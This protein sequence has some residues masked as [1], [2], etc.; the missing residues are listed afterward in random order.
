MPTWRLKNL[1]LDEVSL[2]PKGANRRRFTVFKAL[3]DHRKTEGGM[4]FPPAAFAHVPDPT[5]PSTWKLRLWETPDKKVTAAQVGRAVAALG[6]GGFRGNRVQIPAADLPGV[7][8]KVRSAWKQVHPGEKEVPNAIKSL[9]ND[10]MPDLKELIASVA[11][12]DDKAKTELRKALE[13]APDDV[14]KKLTDAT[15]EQKD[16]LRKALGMEPE[17]DDSLKA[18]VMKLFG[19]TPTSPEPD[20]DVPEAVRKAVDE[21]K[22]SVKKAEGRADEAEKKLD[23]A[24]E[25]IAKRDREARVQQM[26]AKA[27]RY[28]KM[29]S[30][31][32]ISKLLTDVDVKLGA[33]GL[34]AVEALL[35]K[36]EEAFSQ[37]KVFEEI[38]H[39]SRT[40]GDGSAIAKIEEKALELRK[41]DPKLTIEEA[42]SLAWRDNPEIYKSYQDERRRART[43]QE[44]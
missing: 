21:V 44:G 15:D 43:A 14:F 38:G 42:R 12:M 1:H 41:A 39:G 7:K 20:P 4:E 11:D 32:D 28:G 24:L 8:A 5:Q 10:P 23:T 30:P 2:V 18:R 25:T 37:A 13:L 26:V 35:A 16:A 22:A 33:E 40:P 31:D 27:A 17:T 6:P 29:G 36:G 19:L 34:K 9:E 3:H